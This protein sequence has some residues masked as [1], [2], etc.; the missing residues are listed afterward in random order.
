MVSLQDTA[1]N[2]V[3]QTEGLSYGG[4]LDDIDY[5]DE[6]TGQYIGPPDHHNFGAYDAYSHQ[7]ELS[8]MQTDQHAKWAAHGGH[9]NDYLFLLSWTLTAA[10]TTS[11]TSTSCLPPPTRNIAAERPS[12][13]LPNI[14]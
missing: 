5:G 11:S 2:S 14:V 3:L 1:S 12:K 8:V 4:R 6:D 13:G 9:D 7:S 10:P